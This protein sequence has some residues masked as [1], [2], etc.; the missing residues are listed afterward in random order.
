MK[1]L[2]HPYI[3]GLLEVLNSKT[4]LYIVMELVQ[5]KELFE[6]LND[7]G[8]LSEDTARRFFQQLT[9]GVNY[10][11]SKHIVHRDLKVRVGEREAAEGWWLATEA[12]RREWTA[13]S[14]FVRLAV[15]VA[16][17]CRWQPF[18]VGLV[19]LTE[20]LTTEHLR[21]AWRSLSPCRLRGPA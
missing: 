14:H 21:L 1:E 18:L 2:S 11:H 15:A 12:D 20:S 17:R 3:V 4:R 19:G 7:Q 5:G 8:R 10:C 9:D 16:S 6:L 13:A